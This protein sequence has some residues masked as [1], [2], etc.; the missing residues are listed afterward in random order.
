MFTCFPYDI[1]AVDNILSFDSKLPKHHFYHTYMMFE[2]FGV[3]NTR[4]YKRSNWVESM[5]LHRVTSNNTLKQI[6]YT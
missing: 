5:G 2:F 1:I 4:E 6:G 3:S